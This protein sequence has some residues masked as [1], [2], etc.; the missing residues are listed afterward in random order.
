MSP[1]E[2][3][4]KL[5]TYEILGDTGDSILSNFDHV[6]NQ[7]IVEK[8]KKGKYISFH[9]AWDFC[10]TVFYEDGKYKSL[11]MKYQLPIEV[12]EHEDFIEVARLTCEKY[13]SA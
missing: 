11:I 10:A 8:L 6:I 9:Y 13:G 5:E 3:L 12:I 1:I 7:D 2:T 4:Q